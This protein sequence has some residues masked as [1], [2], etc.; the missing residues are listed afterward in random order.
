L[1]ERLAHPIRDVGVEA[2]HARHIVSARAALRLVEARMA[3]Q[4]VLTREPPLLLWAIV[5]EAALHRPVGGTA[6]MTAQ[7]EHL[8]SCADMPQVTLQALPYAVGGHPGM[9][10]SFAIM[11][12][13]DAGAGDV[14]CRR[15]G[16]G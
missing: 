13:P 3:R 14:V 15:A 4:A 8:A 10:G 1:G 6:V 2:A 5:D 9:P 7:L 16:G 12:F 11:R